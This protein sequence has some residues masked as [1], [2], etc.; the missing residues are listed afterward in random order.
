MRSSQKELG[1]RVKKIEKSTLRHAHR[2][3][4][5]R[6]GRLAR[7]RRQVMGWA[8]LVLLLLVV[9][10]VQLVSARQAY[11]TT[12][13]GEGGSFAEGVLGPLE[14]LNP[15]FARSSAEK[16]AARLLF[17]GLYRY[18]RDGHVARD[19]AESLTVNEAE[20]EYTVRLRQDATW[21]DGA[22]VTAKDIIFTV[23]TLKNPDART[24]VSGWEAITALQV[25]SHTVTFRLPNA[26][27]PFLHA[28]TFPIVPQHT[29]H[30]VAPSELREH[31]FSRAPVT[32]GPF[33]LRLLQQVGDVGDKKIAHLVANPRYVHGAPK[34][35]RFQLHVYPTRDAI[36]RA[37]R[38]S[39]ISA[40][41]E[42][43]FSQLPDALRQVYQHQA[44]PLHDGV[45]ALFNTN[46]PVLSSVALRQA[47]VQSVD[48][49]SLRRQLAQ[50]SWP[51]VGPLLHQQLQAIPDGVPVTDSE[52]ARQLL[53]NAGWRLIDGVR[54]KDGHPLELSMVTLKG[55]DYEAAAHYLAGV[56]RRELGIK[57]D[58]QVV[59]PQD[60]AQNVH[61]SILQ[62]RNFDVLI[63]EMVLGG[64]PDG[65]AYWHSSSAS[66]S[67][68]NFAN[69]NS[70]V[71]DDALSSGRAKRDPQQRDRRYQ[72]FVRRWWQDAPAIALY[73]PG[74]D[75]IQSKSV[76]TMSSDTILVSP[77]D[78]Y[79]EV[80]SWTSQ[81]KSVYKT[82]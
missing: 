63:Y 73:Q 34:L 72:A 23:E 59:D 16:S 22:P 1:R 64:D 2:F 14:T 46:S 13:P 39:E 28:L 66:R 74:L 12:V 32:S 40:T 8:V 5:A 75:Y 82:P 62:P 54:R 36:V 24:E 6:L 48:V 81:Q 25:D 41:P 79:A 38:I 20:T 78:R 4:M 7:V 68:L 37:L 52:A 10:V 19:L 27:A 76:R 50:T 33:A 30:G 15:L 31:A 57:S 53:D 42:L 17:A 35:E 56:W 80:T 43:A 67:G 60:P 47:L 18:D 21:S 44:Y 65:F 61:Q 58:I 11:T 77:T 3:V 45:Y 70:A 55:R 26:Y 49:S 29:L 69:Y 71:A 9:S 51:L